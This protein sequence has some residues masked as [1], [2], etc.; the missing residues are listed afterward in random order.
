MRFGASGA[1]NARNT[2]DSAPQGPNVRLQHRKAVRFCDSVLV[3]A[4]H[5]RL[6]RAFRYKTSSHEGADPVRTLVI[7][8]LSAVVVVPLGAAAATCTRHGVELQ[9]LGSGWPGT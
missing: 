4:W 1:Q 5:C 6:I 8:L 9:V 2:T 3:A 7:A